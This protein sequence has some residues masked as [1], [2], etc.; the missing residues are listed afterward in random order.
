LF[1]KTFLSVIMRHLK[2]WNVSGFIDEPLI[3]DSQIN[4]YRMR[5]S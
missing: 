5:N 2:P 3:N 4:A 1:E